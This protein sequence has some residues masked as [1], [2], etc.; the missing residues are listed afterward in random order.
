MIIKLTY[1]AYFCKA[2]FPPSFSCSRISMASKPSHSPHSVF[3]SLAMDLLPVAL[4]RSLSF[5]SAGCSQVAPSL[6]L[7]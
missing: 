6:K 7:C 5:A 4:R 1:S 3:V 2:Y